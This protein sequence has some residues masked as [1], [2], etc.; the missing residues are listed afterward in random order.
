[1]ILALIAQHFRDKKSAVGQREEF[2]I[3]RGKGK[4]LILL[5]HGAPGVGK[6]STAEGVAELFRKPLFQITCG[7]LGTT[8]EEV[9]KA[10][11][12]NFALANR[13]D[14]ILLLDEADVFLAERTKL[15]FKRNGLV[16]VFLRVM[17]YYAGILF[18]TTNRIGDFDE[19]FTSRIHISL[20]Y[21][22]LDNDKTV[23]V[24][25]LNMCMIRE[26]FAKKGRRI[27][28]DEMGIGGF[29]S[30]HFTAHPQARWNGRQIR[31]A[32]QTALALAEFE[33]QGNSHQDIL[34]P[35]AVV[36]LGVKQFEIVRDAY[37][38]FSEYMNNLYGSNSA[39]RAKEAK[40]RAIWVDENN[41]VVADLG[42]G[43]VGGRAMDKR[44]FGAASKIQ[45]QT[46]LQQ[47]QQQPSPAQQQHF[48]Y[49]NVASP[50]PGYTDASRMPRA[51]AD[52]FPPGGQSWD[53]P[54]G[55]TTGA[56]VNANANA[57][58]P[59][60]GSW[61]VQNDALALQ[62]SPLAGG[63]HYDPQQQQQQQQHQA[64]P[65]GFDRGIQEMYTASGPQTPGHPPPSNLPPGSG[66]VY[67]PGVAAP[68]Q[69]WR[70]APSP[71]Q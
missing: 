21:P 25:K 47:W 60:Q 49:Q 1:M 48:G 14:C 7:D 64:Y 43:G 34:R 35:D 32:C 37:V 6:T 65:P 9:E 58:T 63:Q 24:F 31:N 15:D 2:D 54:G 68:G 67:V 41:N 23:K 70:G 38:K 44:A 39:R 29:A 71:R 20:Y 3:V 57:N 26:R 51:Q 19:A 36:T 53:N 17:E 69:P 66:N 27:D 30:H 61:E 56:N 28:I 33:A 4:G 50:H 8:A 18:L 22:E 52:Q 55:R 16:A 46:P 62:Q 5:L 10:L 12:T 59:Y 42:A 40:L 45:P 11:E 13:W